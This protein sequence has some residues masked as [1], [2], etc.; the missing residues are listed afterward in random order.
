MKSQQERARKAHKSVEIQVSKA[1]EFAESTKFLGY[2]T[3]QFIKLLSHLHGL[4]LSRGY[5]ISHL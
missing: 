3:E 4:Y 1:D 5:N 2:E